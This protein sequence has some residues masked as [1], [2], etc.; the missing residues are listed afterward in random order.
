MFS[1]Y[2]HIITDPAHGLAELTYSIFIDLIVFGVLWTAV[3]TKWLKPK[4]KREVHSEIDASHGYVHNE[5]A[6]DEEVFERTGYRSSGGDS[7]V[8]MFKPRTSPAAN[9]DGY[10]PGTRKVPLGDI[11]WR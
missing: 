11:K 4:L 6:T 9:R 2:L 1:E 7:T 10:S 5:G 3:W 8:R